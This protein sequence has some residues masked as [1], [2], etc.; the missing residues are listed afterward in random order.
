MKI[1][2]KISVMLAFIGLS[3]SAIAQTYNTGDIAVINTIIDDNGLGWTK[4]PTDG[5]LVPADWTG[6]KWDAATTSKRIIELNIYN[7]NLSGTLNVSGLSNLEKLDCGNNN[8][9]A[10]NASGLSNLEILDCRINNLTTLNI[11]GLANLERLSCFGN[12]LTALNVSGLENLEELWCDYN[13]LTTLDVSGLANLT[14]LSCGNN[15]LTTL[16]VSGLANLIALGCGNNNLTTLNVNGLSNLK[17]LRCD[18]NNLATLDASGLSN[19][20]WLDCGINNLT[21]LNVSGLLNLQRL[22]CNNNNLTTLNVTGLPTITFLDCRYNFLPNE[23]AVVGFTGVWDGSDFIFSPQ[24]EDNETSIV[25]KKHFGGK[26][27]DSFSAVAALSDGVVAVG[28]SYFDSF[29][30]DDWWG[31]SGK[32]SSDA[33]IVK[34]KFDGTVVWKRNFGGSDEDYFQSVTAVADGIVAVGHSWEGSFGNGDWDG[35]DKKGVLDAIIVKYDNNGEIVWKKNFGGSDNDLFQSVTA[36]ADGVVVVGISFDASFGSGDWDGVTAKGFSDAIIVKYD[37]NGEIVWKNHFGG[38]GNDWFRSV[39]AVAD[40]FVAVGT[41]YA[42]SFNSGDWGDTGKGSLDA[43][44]V[45]YDNDGNMVWCKNFGGEDRDEFNS[46]T[47]VSDGI[48]AVGESY[49]NSF[50]NGDWDGVTAKGNRDAIIVKYDINGER[51]W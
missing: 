34:Y 21:T 43:I 27:N 25:W 48:I 29:D 20:E 37:N 6:V 45:K 35:V 30:D 32:G 24:K 17:I 7:E 28:S 18:N 31:V 2:T 23:A 47:A 38:D 8:L 11:S 33:I 51:I 50:G 14:D 40:G 4:A 1:F 22:F 44:I 39:T 15:N 3:F 46:V 42:D 9:T 10:L 16:D 12:N 41:S 36:V 5:S 19:L 13:N 26:E 49:Y